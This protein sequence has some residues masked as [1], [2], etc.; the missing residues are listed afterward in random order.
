[1]IFTGHMT[2]P[3]VSAQWFCE[4][5]YKIHM[6]NTSSHIVHKTKKS[7]SS[8]TV[9]CGPLHLQICRI[10]HLWTCHKDNVWHYKR[11]TLMIMLC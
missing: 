5:R 4:C 9:E 3:T 2:K 11:G 7:K 6:D 8:S 10:C 1:M